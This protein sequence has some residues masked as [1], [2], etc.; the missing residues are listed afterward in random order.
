MINKTQAFWDAINAN[1]RMSD[2]AAQFQFVPPGAVEGATITTSSGASYSDPDQVA[3]D[4]SQMGAFWRGLNDWPL[5][6]S[7]SAPGAA[8]QY[9]FWSLGISGDDGS[10]TGCYLDYQLDDAYDIV[11]ITIVFD[12]AA[13]EWARD[14]TVTYY[15]SGG[16]VL[17]SESVTDNTEA[18]VVVNLSAQGVERI[19]VTIS[20]WCLPRARARIAE[21]IPGQVYAFDLSN[22]YSLEASNLMRPF[23]NSFEVG[24][25]AVTFDNSDHRFD[26]LNPTGVFAYLRQKMKIDTQ[27]GVNLGGSYDFTNSGDRYLYEIPNDRQTSAA[28]LVCR[29]AVAFVEDDTAR[30]SGASTVAAVVAG[31]FSQ[32]G[33]TDG[34][35][36]DA[37]LQN[38]SCNNYCG[39]NV[40]L[41]NAL[42]AIAI[43]AGGWW[44]IHR[45]GSYEMLPILTSL[46]NP[47]A[48]ITYD[49]ML[50]KPQ[51]VQNPLITAVRIGRSWWDFGTDFKSQQ[52]IY[53]NGTNDGS[54]VEVI[55]TYTP[56][57]TRAEEL[58]QLALDYHA[59]RRLTFT[60]S[61]R[62]NPALE[63]G[64]IISIE[65]DYGFRNIEIIEH[66]LTLDGSG[67]LRG[68]IKGVG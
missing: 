51:I 12:L 47:V 23:S 60:I 18:Q 11:G 31:L 57:T 41:N 6:G 56:T 16:S 55:S 35:T 63:V 4:N 26:F 59:A 45:D 46:V 34:Y 7:T 28:S 32:A 38:I 49:D 50:S 37:S 14:F 1:T 19:R 39:E 43:T 61:Y 5:D 65:T 10:L 2:F 64:D 33:I 17:D 44:K 9:G 48:T 53:T 21:F 22:S 68:T 15:G 25:L 29:P 20:E 42:A 40:N 67:F 54:Q 62:G 36:I 27:I 3:D 52:T 13:N 30:V 58:G 66:T 8:G 24:E